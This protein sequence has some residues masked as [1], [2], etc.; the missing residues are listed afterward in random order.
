MKYTI[1]IL[2]LLFSL[3]LSA[4]VS[5]LSDLDDT[6]KITQASGDPADILG[7]KAYTGMPEFYAAATNYSKEL[8]ILS[9]S[10]SFIRSRIQNVLSRHKIS[11]KSLVLRDNILEDT[12][13]YK[14]KNI[15]KILERTNEDFILIGD[16]IGEDPEA[17]AEIKRLYPDRI[18]AVYIHSVNGRNHRTAA[19]SYWTSFD[20]SLMEYLEGRMSP[21]AVDAIGAKLWAEANMELIFPKEAQCPKTYLVWEWQL[22]T[23]FQQQANSLIN[24]FLNFCQARQSTIIHQ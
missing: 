9:A 12:L 15:Q 18:L 11:Y 10:P 23:A 6:I 22:R 24:K 20:L 1:I 21:R 4:S 8:H 13:N 3:T 14:V 2:S 7:D 17:Y 5:I 19:F 16:D